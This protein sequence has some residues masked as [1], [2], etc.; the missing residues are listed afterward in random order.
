MKAIIHGDEGLRLGEMPT[1]AA[2]KGEVVVA[3]KTAGLNR[4]DL[5]IPARREN[6]GHD[7]ILG[8]DGAGVVEAVGQ[9]VTRWSVGDE[10][11]INPSLNWF[12]KSD[13]SPEG[14]RL[15]GMPDDG[16]FAEKIVIS[17]EQL[18]FRP[19]YLSW[20]ESASIGLAG[21][22]GF[23][24]LITRGKMKKGDTVFVPGAGSGVVTLIIQFAKA[25]GARVIVT[26]R[27]EEKREQA[28]KLGADRAINTH[29]DWNEELKDETI[30][31]VIESVGKATFNRSLQSLKNGGRLVVF[32]ATTEDVIDLDLR[33]L[34]NRQQEIVGS[35]MGSRDELR[36]MLVFAEK[37]HIRP[38]IDRILPLDDALEGFKMLEDSSQF[39]KIVFTV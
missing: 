32:G 33:E 19:A 24:A 6:K 7:L 5:Y 38:V 39:G 25:A 8:S 26:S 16:T 29:A 36:E 13:G 15:L 3:L 23:R 35:M 18:E 37:H 17:E 2:K 34:F 4:R 14:F 11:M 30:D 22:T 31:L 20:E 10:V 1:P 12:E 21:L 9:D 28:L 27:S